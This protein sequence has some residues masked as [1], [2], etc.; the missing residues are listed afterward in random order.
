MTA[1]FRSHATLNVLCMTVE[2]FRHACHYLVHLKA[3][4]H[5]EGSIVVVRMLVKCMTCA[6]VSAAGGGVKSMDTMAMS[7]ASI[8]RAHIGAGGKEEELQ[9]PAD[10]INSVDTAQLNK[11]RREI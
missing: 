7:E 5:R 11:V 1:S 3:H 10:I 9:V 8:K 6:C 4:G 2:K